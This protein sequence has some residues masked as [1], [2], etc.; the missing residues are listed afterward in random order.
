MPLSQAEFDSLHAL[1]DAD[2]ASEGAVL[3]SA[4]LAALDEGQT[5]KAA[6]AAAQ[7]GWIN[8]GLPGASQAVLS[9]IP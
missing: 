3:S 2:D 9:L 5:L 7:A 4:V 1:L 8:G 6:L